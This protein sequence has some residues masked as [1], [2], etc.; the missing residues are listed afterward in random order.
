MERRGLEL[1]TVDFI[2][3]KAKKLEEFKNTS[4]KEED[5]EKVKKGTCVACVV[6]VVVVVVVVFPASDHTREAE[7]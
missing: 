2:R 1:P 4:L 5:V 6:S 3:R 7:V